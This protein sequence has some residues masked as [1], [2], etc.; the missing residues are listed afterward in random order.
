MFQIEILARARTLPT[1]VCQ[2]SHLLV[3]SVLDTV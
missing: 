1:E 2:P 3:V